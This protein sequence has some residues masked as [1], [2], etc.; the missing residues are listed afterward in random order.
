MTVSLSD[1]DDDDSDDDQEHNDD[2]DEDDS[3]GGWSRWRT[4]AA[5]T[6]IGNE[7][8]PL[9]LQCSAV[10][11]GMRKIITMMVMIKGMLIHNEILPLYLQCRDDDGEEENDDDDIALVWKIQKKLRHEN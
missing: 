5:R 2:D 7:I 4:V 3:L 11:M 8:S 9:H 6:V 10:V 1:Y